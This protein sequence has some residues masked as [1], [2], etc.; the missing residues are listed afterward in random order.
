MFT[1]GKRFKACGKAKNLS[2]KEQAE[3]FVTSPTTKGC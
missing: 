3:A 1:F 2:Q